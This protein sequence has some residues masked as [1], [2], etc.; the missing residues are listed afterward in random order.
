MIFF[1]YSAA[2]G[3]LRQKTLCND[4]DTPR[5]LKVGEEIRIVKDADYAAWLTSLNGKIPIDP[6]QIY[7][8]Q[9]TGLTPSNDRYVIVVGT[10]VVQDT[11][12]ADQA[13][14]DFSYFQQQYPGCILIASATA[15]VGW[16][17]DTLLQTLTEPIV[18]SVKIGNIIL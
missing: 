10:N 17:Y 1:F 6:D 2:T 5:Q 9:L 12:G 14:G 15:G 7:L 11:F 13:C 16:I 18:Q 4:T 3:R 8:S